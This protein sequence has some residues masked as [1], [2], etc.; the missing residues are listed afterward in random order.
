M[1]LETEHAVAQRRVHLERAQHG[2]RGVDGGRHLARHVERRL[3]V[4]VAQRDHAAVLNEGRDHVRCR[5]PCRDRHAVDRHMQRR[6][7]ACRRLRVGVG[8][9]GEK[10]SK[11]LE[12]S[13]G[14]RVHERVHLVR[15]RSEAHS[16]EPLRV[17]V[18]VGRDGWRRARWSRRRRAVGRLGLLGDV[19]SAAT[20]SP[21]ATPTASAAATTT[22]T[23]TGAAAAH[24][25]C[26]DLLHL[27]HIVALRRLNE[28]L[29]RTL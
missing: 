3:V 10:P 27:V 19:R 23:T 15:R 28:R 9:V 6:V 21:A 7:A 12:R 29:S 4:A 24:H 2:G 8:F 22:T 11:R 17:R 1:L 5:A 13:R 26:I 16:L 20:T 14:C 18:G 25:F